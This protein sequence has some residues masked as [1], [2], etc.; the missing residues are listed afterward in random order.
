MIQM[1]RPTADAK[2]TKSKRSNKL[3]D[4]RVEPEYVL[5]Q[6]KSICKG[7]TFVASTGSC[8]NIVVGYTDY[9]PVELLHNV[10]AVLDYLV[11]EKYR[12]VGGVVKGGFDG[13]V[14]V[15]V[16]TS[17]S[18]SLPILEKKSDS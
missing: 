13:I 7:T 6:L 10:D 14:D 16:K 8:L 18:I 12:P 1:A 2:L 5:K 4:E 11:N 9:H 17:E 3:K 15:H